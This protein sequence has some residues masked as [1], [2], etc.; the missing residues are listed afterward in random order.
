MMGRLQ[1]EKVFKDPVHRYVHVRDTLIWNLINAREF[2]RLR[3]I[4]QLGTSY[5]TFHGAEHSRFNHS[6][7]VYE[8]MRR[9]LSNFSRRSNFVIT[10]EERLLCLSAALL[11]DIGHGPFSHSFEKVFHTDHEEWTQRILTGNTQ[12]NAV[13]RRVSDDF[14]EKV[15]QMIGKTYPNKLLVSLISSQIDADRMD[16]LLR[17]SYY[18]GTSYGSFDLERVLRVLKPYEDKVVIKHTGMHAVED[19]IAARYQMY[20]QVY[21]HRVTRSA[22][23]ILRNIFARVRYLHESGYSFVHNPKRF[24]PLFSGTMTIEEYIALDEATVL[25]YMSEWSEEADEVLRDL[26]HRFM[27]RRLFKYVEHDE[28]ADN[29]QEMQ[30]LKNLF[31]AIGIDPDYYLGVD[32]P[33]DLPY[34]V[35]R[36]GEEGERTPIYL[37][38]PDGDLKELSRCS[39]IVEAISGK[40]RYDH[41]LYFPLDFLEDGTRDQAIVQEIKR[42]L[43]I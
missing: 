39:V 41:K 12:V 27:D 16:Y 2:Q 8:I 36:S 25:Y 21:F 35:Y 22:E 3:R 33:S 7:G 19:Y 43:C 4:R 6:L 26:C 20:W 32:S 28:N 17:D 14:P 1:E 10:E 31:A 23:V 5:V 9:I 15:A 40:R 38:M 13:L 37:L 42:R 11:H 18:T 34:D 24:M 30:E 29:P